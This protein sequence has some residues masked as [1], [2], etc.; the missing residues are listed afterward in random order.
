MTTAPLPSSPYQQ[1][2]GIVLVGSIIR[3]RLAALPSVASSE[4]QACL[5]A[6]PPIIM[7]PTTWR[8][9]TSKGAIPM[10]SFELLPI[11]SLS[12]M[13]FL[14]ACLGAAEVLARASTLAR[15]E[16]LEAADREPSWQEPMPK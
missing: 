9:G 2:G 16:A 1:G 10:P 12:V 4:D 7:T 14:E 6:T 11:D 8:R 13:G 3:A 5:L 15:M